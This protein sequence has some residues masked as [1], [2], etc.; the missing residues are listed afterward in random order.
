MSGFTPAQNTVKLQ[1]R[2]KCNVYNFRANYLLI[3]LVLETLCLLFL[4]SPSSIL[5]LLLGTFGILCLN[6]TFA[7]SVR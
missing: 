3:V 4:R 7:G 6:D 2:I 5:A 1:A